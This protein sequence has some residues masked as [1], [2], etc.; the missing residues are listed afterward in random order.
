MREFLYS[1]CT[2]TQ[3]KNRK[4]IDYLKEKRNRESE[5]YVYA[6]IKM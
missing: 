4:N 2:D 1:N 5:K 6:K 3:E